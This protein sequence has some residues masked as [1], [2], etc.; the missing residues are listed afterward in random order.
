[1]NKHHAVSIA[2]LLALIILSFPLL[3]YAIIPFGG[4]VTVMIPCVGGDLLTVSTF[5]GPMQ[6]FWPTGLLP[7][8]M[9]SPPHPLQNLLGEVAPA[10]VPCFLEG[11][12]FLV[13]TGFPII[14]HGE[15]N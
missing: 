8:L 11:T 3:S 4:T 9:F 5:Y 2:A 14:F 13:G 15:S 6:V 10:P 7:Y 12:P 1:M